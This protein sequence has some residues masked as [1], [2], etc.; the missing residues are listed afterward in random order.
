MD[1]GAFLAIELLLLTRV[2]EIEVVLVLPR[3]SETAESRQR[4]FVR[5]QSMAT[6]IILS[7]RPIIHQFNEKNIG[8]EFLCGVAL[9]HKD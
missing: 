9:H 7:K 3:P 2:I 4:G 6:S 8:F 5:C 1:Y